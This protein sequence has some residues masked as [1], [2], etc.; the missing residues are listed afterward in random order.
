MNRRVSIR[1]IAVHDGK[2][3]CVRLK[4]Y[5][6][7]IKQSIARNG[8]FWCVPGGGLDLGE[9]LV[10]GLERELFEELGV[11]PKVGGLLYIQQNLFGGSEHLEFFFHVTNAEDY[12]HVDLSKTSHGS[13]EIEEIAFVD[14]AATNVLPKFLT[15][16]NIPAKI[17]ANDP[18]KI[19]NFLKSDC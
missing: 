16:E 5:N 13:I 10:P 1:A 18:P 3:L 12:L 7:F 2:L 17:A 15:T 19:F 4:P 9:A 14:P 8:A 11:T 6:P